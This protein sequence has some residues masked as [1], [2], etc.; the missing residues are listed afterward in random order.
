MKTPI[1][2]G[3]LYG[4]F[5]L[6]TAVL[7]Q[8]KEPSVRIAGEVRK[9]LTLYPA[10]INSMKRTVVW[11][12]EFS[13]LEYFYS[14]VS[15]QEL[16]KQAGVEVKTESGKENL[17]WY[18]LAIGADGSEAVFSAAE[19]D[20]AF[21][22]KTIILADKINDKILPEGLGPFRLIVPGEENR[23]RWL[24]EVTALVVRFVKE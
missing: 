7:A 24:W 3:F 13:G 11:L 22:E 1:L 17:A 2:I 21:S 15:I 14:G 23:I 16:L 10:D 6:N 18:V 12:K 8:S 19:L 20:S 5:L 4:L 9:P